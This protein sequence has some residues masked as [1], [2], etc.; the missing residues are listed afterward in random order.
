MAPKPPDVR[1]AP[2]E[3]WRAAQTR[4][5]LL[6]AVVCAWLLAVLL[7][8]PPA[9]S[10]A[11]RLPRVGYLGYTSPAV[12]APYIGAF[13]RRLAELGLTEGR[14][15]VLVERYAGGRYERLGDLAGELVRAGVDVLVTPG[16][17]PTLAATAVTSTIPI[18]MMEVG[19][20]VAYRLVASLE[21]PGGNVTG[22]SS[23]FANLAPLHLDLLRRTVPGASRVA[24]LWNPT[25]LAEHRLWSDRQTTARVF[26]WQLQ[27]VP[28]KAADELDAALDAVAAG[29]ADALYSVGDPVILMQRARVAEFALKH[30]LPSLFGW[31][32]FADAG[33]LMAYGP[34]TVALY[35]HAAEYVVRILRGAR[36]GDLP[37]AVPRNYF[38]I[39]LK[40]A[41]AL[42]L[43][44][45][46]AVLRSAD[47][48]L[49]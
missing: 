20:P 28:V 48:T 23:L 43:T 38:V 27:T 12:A 35:G 8:A 3:P 25:N 5:G 37:V 30:R 9:A 10:T 44:I 31:S 41:R 29:G 42:G 36:P 45:P 19:D 16:S 11:P 33:G 2:A 17:G 49:D 46:E 34:S 6:A 4:A 14:D 7:P 22:V 18:V 21:H 32:E 24:V 47:S 40:T 39:N 15:V 13:R 26:G 1:R